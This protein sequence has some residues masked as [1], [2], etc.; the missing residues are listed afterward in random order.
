MVKQIVSFVGGLCNF[1][2]RGKMKYARI[3]KKPDFDALMFERNILDGMHQETFDRRFRRE[4]E[5]VKNGLD[6]NYICCYGN[7]RRHI[8]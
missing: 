4:I 5:R 1:S 8:T 6:Y 7:P 2:R 3:F